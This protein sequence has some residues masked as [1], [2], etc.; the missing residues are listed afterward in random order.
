MNF[1]KATLQM[2]I[3][4]TSDSSK[5]RWENWLQFTQSRLV[6]RFT[7]RGF[8]VVSIPKFVKDK[9]QAAFQKALERGF[10]KIRSEGDVDVISN[11]PNLDPKFVDLGPLQWEVIEDL[12]TYHEQWAGGIKLIPTSA[13][14]IRAY[15]NGSTLVMHYDRVRFFAYIY[16]YTL[17][18]G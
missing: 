17:C 4:C 1:K 7:E 13:Y 6:P 8:E 5:L 18:F 16:I 3:I 15:Q 11:P 14:G 9:L 2:L 10:D 12:K